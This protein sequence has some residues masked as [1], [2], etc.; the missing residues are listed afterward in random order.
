M[1]GC[2]EEQPVE[3]PRTEAQ[4]VVLDGVRYR[5]PMFRQLNTR[6]APDEQLW[7]RPPAGAGRGA[8]AAFVEVCN[9]SG[10]PLTPPEGFR[11]LDAFGR[12]F[13]PKDAGNRNEFAYEPRR[14]QP[15]E[16]IPAAGSVT[17][18]T[19]SGSALLFE[20]PFDVLENR[21]LY[22]QLPRLPGETARTPRIR[23]DV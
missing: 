13:M 18:Q 8:F 20:L 21:P 23:L 16:C 15:D 6:V 19:L 12:S 4:S 2:G 11:L 17:D 5:A 14:L 10:R 1:A 3:E 7:D 9:V 22:L